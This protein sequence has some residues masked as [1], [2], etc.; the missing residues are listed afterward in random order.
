MA[1]RG[2]YINLDRSH[3]RRA[4]MEAQLARLGLAQR[5]QRFA[6]VDGQQAGDI[7]G[8]LT[9]NELGCFTSH[10]NLLQQHRDATEHLHII[11]DDAVLA[12]RIAWFME[13]VINSGMLDDN[14]LLFTDM[15]VPP[16]IHFYREA[17]SR[18]ESNIR[19]AKDGTAIDVRVST[20]AYFACTSSYL[21]NG[22]S[23]GRICDLLG[24]ELENGPRCPI[25]LLIRDKVADGALR[26]RCLFP[27]LTTIDPAGFE[28]TI[29][30]DDRDQLSARAMDLLRHSF[31][32]ECDLTATLA[33]VDQSLPAPSAGLH[34]RLLARVLGFM[35][36][37]AFHLM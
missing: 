29:T 16:E 32:V 20:V 25:D 26:A 6:A 31:F 1:Y 10:Y 11:E 33:L 12:K 37:D 4:A 14:D 18:Y 17:R 27:F 9:A 34:A 35:T 24:R 13:W 30:R 3:E 8:V 28:S 5:Y 19:R 22:R 21:V 36:S 15:G 23:I 7:S 2:Y